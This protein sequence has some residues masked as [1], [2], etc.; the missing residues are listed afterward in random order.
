V[1]RTIE[2]MSRT[3]S[4]EV[5]LPSRPELRPNMT[6]TVKIVFETTPDALVVPVNVI[7]QINNE[8]VVYVAEVEGKRTVAKRKVITVNGVFD[9]QAQV[10][11]LKAGDKLITFGYQGLND[12]DVVKI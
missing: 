12:G 4:I 6:A 10:Q 11:G 3:F 5:N 2:A 1:G 8:K 9:N 7:Q